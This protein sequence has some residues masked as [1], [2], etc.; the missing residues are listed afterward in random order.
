[1]RDTLEIG[2]VSASCESAIGDERNT[3]QMLRKAFAEAKDHFMVTN[4]DSQLKGALNAVLLKMG[5]EHPDRKRLEFE[6]T[7]LGKLSA[8][9]HAAQAGLSVS[10]P[11]TVEPPT[12][13]YRPIGVMRLWHEVKS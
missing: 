4:T 5:E 3:E 12:E 7:M 1:M 6:I 2:L 13:D 9:L 8:L 11:E 10:M